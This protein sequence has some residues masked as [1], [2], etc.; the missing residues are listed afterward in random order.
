[1]KQRLFY[2]FLVFSLTQGMMA[3]ITSLG[4]VE[5]S[6]IQEGQLYYVIP[7][8]RFVG[9]KL[10]VTTPEG[11][12][13]R[14]VSCDAKWEKE[15]VTE[16]LVVDFEVRGDTLAV[17]SR[18]TLYLSVDCGKSYTTIPLNTFIGEEFYDDR[19]LCHVEFHPKNANCIYVAYRGIS[20]SSDF[21]KTWV[22]LPFDNIPV[23]SYTHSSGPT[24]IL[25]NPIDPMHVVTYGNN[26]IF[27][28]SDVLQSCDG[29]ASWSFSYYDGGVSEIHSVAFHPTD[30]NKM[31]VCGLETYLMQEQQG[32]RLENTYDPNSQYYEVLVNLFDVIYDPRNPD[33][34]YGAD[35][36]IQD[37]NIVILRSVDGGMTWDKYYTIESDNID[38]AVKLAFKD[39]LLAI[40]S[41]SS[42]IY[43]LD[44]DEIEKPQ[45][46]KPYLVTEGK[47][48]AVYYEQS[49]NQ[50]QPVVTHTFRL[51]GD[52]VINGFTYKKKWMSVEKDLSDWSLFPSYMREENGKV[53]VMNSR[54]EEAL[55]FDYNAQVGDTLCLTSKQATQQ[56]YGLV[57]SIDDVVLEHSDGK[58]RKRYEVVL[59][60]EA[61]SGGVYFTDECIYIH[62]DVG[63]FNSPTYGYGLGDHTLFNYGNKFK[64]L[65]VHDNGIALYQ[66]PDGC[67]KEATSKTYLVTEGKQWA[68]ERYTM[69]GVQG[70]YSYCL[71][72]DTIINGKEYKIEH[73]GCGKDL[74]GMK[75]SGRYMREENG[76]VYSYVHTER[77]KDEDEVLFFDFNLEDGDTIVYIP[78]VYSLHVMDVYDAVIPH[79][80]GQTR[81]CYE[82]EL[83]GI[84]E[85]EVCESDDFG[86]T[87]VEGIGNLCSG[88]SD[89][90]FGLVGSN[91]RLLYVKQGDTI[92][93]QREEENPKEQSKFF[94]DDTKWYGE[95][96]YVY[97]SSHHR[98]SISYSLGTDTVIDGQLGQTLY[99]DG[100]YQG[101]FFM[102]GESVWFKPSTIFSW[103][104]NI[105]E[106]EEL[107]TF[108]LY[109]FSLQVGDTIFYD[110]RSLGYTYEKTEEYSPNPVVKA[111]R[112]VHGRKVI[113]FD[114]GEQWIEGIG[115]IREP[116]LERWRPRL[117]GPGNTYESIYQV[118]A[119]SATIWFK[120]ELA[121]PNIEPWLKAGM[122]WTENKQ[123]NE[124]EDY[125]SHQIKLGKGSLPGRF[126]VSITGMD[127]WEKPFYELQVFNNKVY[128]LGMN[129]IILCYDFS[130]SVGNKVSLLKSYNYGLDNCYYYY[131]NCHVTK[132]DTVVYYGV[133]R[134]RIILSGDR[135]DV[136]VE[137]IGSL[138]RLFPLDNLDTGGDYSIM[139][140]YSKVVECSYKGNLLYRKDDLEITRPTIKRGYGLYHSDSYLYA[141][142]MDEAAG[143]TDSTDFARWNDKTV[144]YFDVDTIGPNAFSGATFRQG[145]VLYFTDRLNTILKDAFTDIHIMERTSQEALIS[146]DLTLVFA[147]T[148]PPSIDKNH[149]MD[150]ADSTY[151]INYVV[152]DL[153]IYIKD[154]IQWAYTSLMTID[155]FVKGYISPENEVTVN[156]ST[157]VDVGVVPDTGHNGNL[158]LVVHARPRKDIPVRIGE[159]ENKDIYSR[160]PAWMR[161]TMELKITD[162]EGTV[163]YED[164]KQCSAYG[165]CRFDVSFA[166]PTNNIIH[167][168]SRSIDMFGRATEWAVTTF[169]LDTSISPIVAPNTPYYDLQGRPVA[170]PTRGI[171]IRNGRK[172]VL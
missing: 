162:T 109:D 15:S 34:L 87:F 149:I 3:Q 137:G 43:L 47:Q 115:S 135:D 23:G 99:R 126:S 67:Y 103:F 26:P 140:N 127:P 61:M 6:G 100:E 136:W 160:A 77:Y 158:D 85:G 153:E 82:V 110:E 62:E 83:W 133:P 46:P 36:T 56:C 80:D 78:D 151:R 165:E 4:L 10:Y 18:D 146:D 45:A 12:Y 116:F 9:D 59:G 159:G 156:D 30:K 25:F 106:E 48:W 150:Y 104:I 38:Y 166:C 41:Y 65:C 145:Q 91:Q 120:G 22:Q 152:P 163:L 40:Y 75:P 49:W 122:T 139:A 68:V 74:S 128:G 86:G 54:G 71:Q 32:Q 42:G 94:A 66:S 95:E 134:K 76:R 98:T 155:D 125:V 16:T 101:T 20:Y 72:G 53:Y 29:G 64:L 73:E 138:T 129:S 60:R 79:S 93:Y 157:Q 144:I 39:N 63:M 117:S 108:L 141:Y 111:V 13:K 92:L 89:P 31:I 102:K 35:M 147:G 17:L 11:L 88:L 142:T 84:H 119:D 97:Y 105:E 44:V 148:N 52:T 171:Y 168:Y 37:K 55:W 8:M 124:G 5:E 81:K 123:Y 112:E 172:V 2:L 27:T 130:L 170:N 121:N 143:V 58:Q 113:D 96:D 118:V 21:G 19:K 90:G 131:D 161:Y 107:P 154:D 169:N 33:I 1:M 50:D 24:N 14:D 132:V 57:T 28:S 114:D 51:Q 69:G 164:A 167:I 7:Q 70:V